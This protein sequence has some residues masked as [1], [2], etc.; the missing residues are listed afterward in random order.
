MKILHASGDET[1]AKKRV[2]IAIPAYGDMCAQFVYS[3]W[4]SRGALEK[5]GIDHELIILSGG[6]HVDDNRNHIVQLFLE[7]KCTDLVTID[8][9]TRWNADDLVRLVQYDRDVVAGIAPKKADPLDFACRL[10]P[11]ENWADAD[12]LLEAEG[13]GAAFLKISRG[14][15]CKLAEQAE[16]YSIAIKGG[17]VRVPLIF[18]RTIAGGSRWGGDYSFC[19]KWR[20]AGGRIHIDP[21][22]ILGHV[23]QN[24]WVGSLG[25]HLR[26]KHGLTGG[27]IAEL[28]SKIES[29]NE[30]TRDFI[31]LRH[32]WGNDEWT[33]TEDMLQCLLLLARECEGPI[34][35][36]GSGLSTLVMATAGKRILSLEH[37]SSWAERVKDMLEKCRLTTVTV[38][39]A[40]LDGGWYSFPDYLANNVAMIVVDGP[41]RQLADRS[42]VV[43]HVLPADGCVWVVDDIGEDPKILEKITLKFGVQFH[44]FGRFAVGRVG[45]WL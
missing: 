43:D 11:G 32:E 7:S 44:N 16:E 15:A 26:A 45:T 2:M 13:A 8:D 24:E 23:G 12:G 9:D 34:L 5:A 3:L 31:Q 20:A 41:P 22:I 37:K 35:E 42:L 25:K 30:E 38:L 29:G 33:A 4:A 36:C 19:N 28:I 39:N 27:Y 10:V 40:S 21:E 18:E 17:R 14:A 6:C 1:G